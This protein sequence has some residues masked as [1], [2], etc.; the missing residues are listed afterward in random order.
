MIDGCLNTLGDEMDDHPPRPGQI[1]AFSK[2][3]IHEI[4]FVLDLD[5]HSSLNPASTR[6]P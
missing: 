1:R 2:E 5:V 4:G 3:T 6:G